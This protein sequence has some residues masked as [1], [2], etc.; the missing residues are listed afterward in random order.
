MGAKRITLLKDYKYP[1]TGKIRKKGQDM[2]V[3]ELKERELIKSG[4]V[5]NHYQAAAPAE[6]RSKRRITKNK[7]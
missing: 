5:A 6:E 7:S 4:H 1:D 2:L 3:D